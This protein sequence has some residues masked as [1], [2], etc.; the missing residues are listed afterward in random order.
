MSTLPYL[1]SI[2]DFFARVILQLK[3]IKEIQIGKEEDKESPLA[4]NRI[5]YLSD[6]KI[7]TRELVQLVNTFN[8]VV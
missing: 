4:G 2:L 6:P 7:S 8:E 1:F 5:V 3:E